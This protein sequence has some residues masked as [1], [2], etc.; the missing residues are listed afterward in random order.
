MN[1]ETEIKL[2]SFILCPYVQ[3]SVILLESK[4]VRYQI[5]YI[6]LER[7]PRWFQQLSPLGRVPLL[8]VDGEVLFES[9]VILDYID[10]SFSPRFHPVDNLK[11]AQHKAWIEFGS[12]L[13]VLQHELAMATESAVVEEKRGDLQ[14]KL[15]YL[16]APLE[17][18]LFGDSTHFSLVDA[19]FAPLFMRLDLLTRFN[20]L[21][22]VDYPQS[23]AGWAERL[24][25]LPCVRDSVVEDFPQRFR[26]YLEKK[27]AWLVIAC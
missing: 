6:D 16:V 18:G 17:E 25:S 1:Q 9:A 19:A 20:P 4:Q 5:E 2:V 22:K 24:A 15:D 12:S 26:S 7:P 3:R 23:V 21:A 13:L 27:G 10:E 8:L 11:R 14:A